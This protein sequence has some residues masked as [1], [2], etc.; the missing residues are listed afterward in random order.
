M[1]Q[2]NDGKIHCYIVREKKI[3][4]YIRS[5]CKGNGNNYSSHPSNKNC[6]LQKSSYG[7]KKEG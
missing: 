6:K 1:I 4:K 3:T 7:E 2:R 5:L